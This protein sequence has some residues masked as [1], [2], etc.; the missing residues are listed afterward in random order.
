MGLPKR[1]LVFQSSIF[2]GF[3]LS[4]SGRVTTCIPRWN[5][6]SFGCFIQM[7]GISLAKPAKPRRD[8]LFSKP[9]CAWDV[10][11]F[12]AFGWVDKKNGPFLC[13]HFWMLQIFLWRCHPPKSVWIKKLQVT[14][15]HDFYDKKIDMSNPQNPGDQHMA[16]GFFVCPKTFDAKQPPST[17]P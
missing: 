7:F 11:V 16:F 6:P 4:V 3:L 14:H 10:V 9:M 2:R 5:R 13:V 15:F 8:D 1:K 12:L 17:T